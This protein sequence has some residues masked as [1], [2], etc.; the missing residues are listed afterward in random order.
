MEGYERK[1]TYRYAYMILICVQQIN[2]NSIV[3]EYPMIG[4][5]AEG[6]R[7]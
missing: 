1:I 5:K 3:Q 6:I 7:G 4:A 2:Y